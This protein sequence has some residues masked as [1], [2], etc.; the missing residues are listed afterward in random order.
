VPDQLLQYIGMPLVGGLHQR[1][2]AAFSL[3]GIHIGAVFEQGTHG[4][5]IA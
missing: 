2:G 4:I 3:G 1:G 5:G